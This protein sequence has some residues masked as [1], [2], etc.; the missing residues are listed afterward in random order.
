MKRNGFTLIEL[1]LVLAIIGI[2]AAIAIPALLG[3]RDNA[4]NRATQSN[5]NTISAAIQL[6][7]GI[8]EGVPSAD[9]IPTDL[10]PCTTAVSVLTAVSN[11]GEY[12]LMKNPFNTANPAYIFNATAAA[13]GD[14]G[15]QVASLNGVNVARITYGIKG[16]GG[17]LQVNTV[18]KLPETSLP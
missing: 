8:V 6:A 7:F 18:P 15:I 11:R 10:V 2:I 17:A 1:L 14:V 4:R 13:V 16:A 3:Q 12:V 5:A 9:R